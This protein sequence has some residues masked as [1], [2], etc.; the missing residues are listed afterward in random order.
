MEDTQE[1][2][3]YKKQ[4]GALLL[5]AA[6][7]IAVYINIQ[8][9]VTL[10]PMVQE[11]FNISRAQVGLYSSF[12]F[13]SALLISVFSG[14]IVDRLGTKKGLILGVA[15]V[16]IMMLLHS[17]SPLY[18]ILL[19]LAFFTGIA[20]SIITPAINRGV[21]E[22][23]EPSRRGFSM[24]IVYGGAG[25]G[26]FLGAVM[27]PFFGEMIGWRTA[28][29]FSSIFAILVALIVYQFYQQEYVRDE[30]ENN[31][32]E[33]GSTSLKEELLLFLRNRYL[34]SICMMG[35]VFGMSIS[36]VVGHFSLYLTLDL[37]YSVSFAGLGLGLFH[38]GGIL[39]QPIW[40]LI[41]EKVLKG[42][43]RKGLFLL[44]MLISGLTLFFGLVVSRFYFPSYAILV[45]SF[46]LGFCI[47]GV[48][49]IYFT[50]VGELVAKE[51]IGVVTGISLIFPRSGTMIAPPLFGLVA[52]LSGTY[53]SSWIILGI[54]VFFFTVAF[55]Y[56]S[57]K[58]SR[59]SYK[60]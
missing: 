23:S 49:A 2:A 33:D 6:A 12:Y 39:G 26:G 1:K 32:T 47:M 28:L 29:V 8:G 45:F 57:H 15:V 22:V 37:T 36:S 7:N 30:K 31:P 13:L 18:G 21:L 60:H 53:S 42:D 56:F 3:W 34:L 44:G 52:D 16:G 9:F 4:W 50:A 48:I 38:I 46:L 19:I 11:E 10:L 17:F 20:F 24:G 59:S 51:R 25:L 58:Y 43:R 5:L 41:N 27:L 35:I 14:R 40:G 55:F 54:I